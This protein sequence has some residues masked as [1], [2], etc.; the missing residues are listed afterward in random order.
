[1][2]VASGFY[3][4]FLN[5]ELCLTNGNLPRSEIVLELQKIDKSLCKIL[6]LD[7]CRREEKVASSV[8]DDT[9]VVMPVQATKSCD[10]KSQ[11]V[12]GNLRGGSEWED[13]GKFPLSVNTLV[14]YS[15]DEYGEA[16][17]PTSEKHKD[18]KGCGLVTYFFTKLA[19][20]L[21]LPLPAVLVEVRQKVD[22]FITENA[23][24]RRIC[25]PQVLVFDDR[26]MKNINL[27]AESKGKGE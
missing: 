24:Y 27:L 22:A 10:T 25:N 2:T 19:S 4:I 15:T 8:R 14:I 9:T 6:L 3:S 18:M 1:M 12:I 20:T 17:Y 23:T 26:L 13:M 16:F 21:N 11:Q 7:S 5:K